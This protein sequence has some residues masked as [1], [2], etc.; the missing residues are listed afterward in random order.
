MRLPDRCATAGGTVAMA[1][2]TSA[3]LGPTILFSMVNATNAK[4]IAFL[5]EEKLI[6]SRPCADTSADTGQSPRSRAAI[7]AHLDL[8]EGT[9]G[10][11][12][13]LP[14]GAGYLA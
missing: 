7:I 1:T 13:P 3:C 11:R 9:G 5:E 14:D 4:S 6:V 12:P 8:A 2:A 10:P